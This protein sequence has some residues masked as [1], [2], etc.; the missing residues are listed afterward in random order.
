MKPFPLSSTDDEPKYHLASANDVRIAL[1]KWKRRYYTLATLFV[2]TILLVVA[3]IPMS[4]SP[5]PGAVRSE[6]YFGNSVFSFV[7]D[8]LRQSVECIKELE[9]G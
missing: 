4:D 8:R 5:A 1:A 6:A 9:R 2:L 3:Y 7:V